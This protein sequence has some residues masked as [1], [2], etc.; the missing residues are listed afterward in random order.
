MGD[1]RPIVEMAGVRLGYGDT[2]VAR[3]VSL[4]LRKGEFFSLLG[5]SG[6][7]K[8]T[9]LRALAGFLDPD[10]GSIRIDGE[11][12]LGVP[13]N[14]RP[15]NMVFQNYAIFPHL[16]I[17]GN[18]AFGLRRLGL[19]KAEVDR[20]VR[21]ALDM[22]KLGVMEGRRVDQLSG[23]QR[24]RVALARAIVMRP[25]VLLL[26]EP[27]SALDKK[28]REEMR[29][30]LRHLQQSLGIT[31]VMVT[32]DQHEAMSMSDRIG[33]MLGG[34]LAQVDTPAN[35][36]ARP[37]DRE[38]ASFIGA[39]NLFPAT[40]FDAPD[41]RLGVDI[42]AWGRLRLDVS[43]AE[44]PAG[45]ALLVG[46]RPEQV[47][48]GPERPAACDACARGRIVDVAFLGESVHYHVALDGLETPCVALA[49]NRPGAA[50]HAAGDDVWLS[51]GR[52][53][54]IPLQG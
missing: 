27:L 1:D 22:V 2:V 5:P 15:T 45:E 34:R 28:L 53:S 19:A 13:P 54:I 35:V 8:T 26:D 47:G 6:C 3:D 30:E 44:A 40:P 37:R 41:G 50:A 21:Q 14:R 20:Q 24:Q 16:D 32:H 31:F 48:I 39:I 7:G 10:A 17:A 29:L 11:E 36:Y 46:V 4:G 52:S 12:M 33:V 42:P 25:K 43:R 49:T 23:G 51:V 9:I 18:V 38:V